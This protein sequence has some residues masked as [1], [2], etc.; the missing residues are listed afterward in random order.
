MAQSFMPRLAEPRSAQMLEMVRS[1]GGTFDLDVLHVMDE[2]DNSLIA[3]EVLSGAGSDRFVYH[4]SIN[5]TEVSGISVVG[6][7]HLANH[8][9]G[10]RHRLVG[11]VQKIGSLFEYRA[12]PSDG[13]AGDIQPRVLHELADQPDY[14]SI[15]CEVTDIKTGNSVQ[16]ECREERVGYSRDGS[17]YDKPNYQKIAQSKAYRNAVLSLIPQDVQLRW[18]AEMLKIKK[19]AD[20]TA[21]VIDEKRR[22][23]LRFAAQHGLALERRAV[24]H[25]GL[26]QITGLGDAAR[27]SEAAFV[28]S[29]RSLGLGVEQ[30]REREPE[31]GT[32][33][34]TAAAPLAA[35]R[36]GRPPGSARRDGRE[37]AGPTPP[38]S[39]DEQEQEQE[40]EQQ[41]SPPSGEPPPRRPRATFAE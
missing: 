12:F 15:V 33:E 28:N 2:R 40:Q 26:D 7:R 20:I 34:T 30:G 17:P 38:G 10:L 1:A 31:I 23:V 14:Y 32:G 25:L 18:K 6:A 24:E 36:R 39:A 11:Y 29:A 3:D 27:V 9:H 16:V 19:G 4:F 8:Y 35:R 22:N 37:S 13:F 5:G 21:S 41:E